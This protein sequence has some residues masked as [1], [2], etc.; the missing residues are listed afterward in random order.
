[1]GRHAILKARQRTQRERI[2][3]TAQPR[4]TNVRKLQKTGEVGKNTFKTPSLPARPLSDRRA[5]EP[6]DG[7][8]DGM[9]SRYHIENKGLDPLYS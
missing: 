1:M 4:R 5:S 2:E 3:E 7:S 6:E 9:V 8:T